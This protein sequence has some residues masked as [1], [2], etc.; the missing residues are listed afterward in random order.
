MSEFMILQID[1]WK[2][3]IDMTAT[4]DYSAKEAAEHC[5]CAYCRNFYAAIDAAYPELRPFLARFGIDI[6]APDELIPYFPP[7]EC[8]CYYAVAGEI[9]SR[10]TDSLIVGGLKVY[11]QLPEEAMI[12]TF[13]EGPHF[14]LSTDMI[15]LT[16]V[17]DEPMEETVSPAYEPSF[18]RRMIN[19]LLRRAPKDIINS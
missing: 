6:E 1:D 4:M 15:Y 7:T 14:F 17:L 9:I 2:F 10:G 5:T 16:W 11:P 12:N 18:I 19:R 8:V 13:I 3:D